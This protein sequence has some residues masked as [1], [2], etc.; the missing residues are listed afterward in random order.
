MK[1]IEVQIPDDI[2]DSDSIRE[3]FRRASENE[4][5]ARLTEI[6]D[7]I[8]HVDSSIEDMEAGI[9]RL[10]TSRIAF[11]AALELLK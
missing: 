5:D 10:R 8:E 3:T 2:R 4:I 1:K 11:Q 9:A 7:R 6:V